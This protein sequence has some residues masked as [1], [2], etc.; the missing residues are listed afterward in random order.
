MARP[1]PP[2]RIGASDAVAQ[3]IRILRESN[4][5]TPEALV[6]RMAKSGCPIARSAIYKIEA[7]QR[8]VDADELVAFASLFDVTVDVLVSAPAWSG[9]P[10]EVRDEVSNI[11][12]AEWHLLAAREELERAEKEVSE[13]EFSLRV[14][15]IRF[16]SSV[17]PE[18]QAR[19]LLASDTPQSLKNHLS[20]EAAS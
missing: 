3:N 11:R 10:R 4:A 19:L 15:L 12:G 16:G 13:A 5:W 1:N 17:A 2:R 20:G 6:V 9:I 7:G 14:A 18:V 8:A